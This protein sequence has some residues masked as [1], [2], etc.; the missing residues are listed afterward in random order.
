MNNR[1][2]ILVS[3]LQNQL[4]SINAEAEA[5]KAQNEEKLKNT[6]S[7]KTN[8]TSA[9]LK[10]LKAELLDLESKQSTIKKYYTAYFGEA[11]QSVQKS[12]YCQPVPVNMTLYK[13][14]LAN[15]NMKQAADNIVNM[16]RSN[17]KY[18]EIQID[19]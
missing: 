11:S 4:R 8:E 10:A 1:L 5:W 17:L 3:Q 15:P 7:I 12:T 14:Q 18:L 13:N 9:P 16:A 19:E 6:I 2:D